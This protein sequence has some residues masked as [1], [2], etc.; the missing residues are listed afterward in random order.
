MN[1]NDL[2]RDDPS[3]PPPHHDLA[4]WIAWTGI[5][6]LVFIATSSVFR[7]ATSQPISETA[8]SAI[9]TNAVHSHSALT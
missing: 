9:T 7:A 8:A 3:K 5:A 4:W 2:D 1:E 6:V